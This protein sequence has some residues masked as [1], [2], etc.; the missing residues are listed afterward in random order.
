MEMG[1]RVIRISDKAAKLL[2]GFNKGSIDKSIRFLWNKLST[3][4][5]ELN[6]WKHES[7]CKD[8]RELRR[9]LDK[10]FAENNRLREKLIQNKIGLGE[11]NEP[12]GNIPSAE[13]EQ[14]KV[15]RQ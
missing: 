13:A 12:T 9:L 5:K 3:Q 14:D 2:T 1:T 15:A 10:L 11:A 8:V 4:G 7:G 6:Q